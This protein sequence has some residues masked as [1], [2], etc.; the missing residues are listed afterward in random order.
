MRLLLGLLLLSISAGNCLADVQ[1]RFATVELR[2]PE[3]SVYGKKIIVKRD[4]VETLV[5]QGWHYSVVKVLKWRENEDIV[6]L[7]ILSG[8]TSC[9]T[10]YAILHVSDKDAR[11][12]EPFGDHG[13][14]LSHFEVTP[15]LVQFRMKRDFPAAIEY[16]AVTYDGISATVKDVMEDDTGIKPAGPEKEVLRWDGVRVSQLFEDP[17]ERIRFTP[18]LT[19]EQLERL[20]HH[21]FM[22][23]KMTLSDGFIIGWGFARRHGATHFGYI[24]I[25]VATGRPFAAYSV[26]GE[27]S[28]FGALETDLP[29]PLRDL[30]NW[31]T[32]RV[33]EMSSRS[34][35]CLQK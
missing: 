30:I 35:R 6:V 4:A 2:A 24:A 5:A 7:N 32:K 14:Q 12:S 33:N 31:N 20:R 18:I 26:C 1:T 28:V 16:Q 3:D 27:L 15:G 11:L 22:A 25:E 8:G 10:S 19:N 13:Y 17:T 34:R 9:C 23:S 21:L 29:Q